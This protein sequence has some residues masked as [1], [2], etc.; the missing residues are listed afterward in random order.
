VTGE[1]G[2]IDHGGVG[3][4]LGSLPGNAFGSISK[5]FQWAWLPANWPSDTMYVVFADVVAAGL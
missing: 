4:G 3:V 2:P 1:P 5:V